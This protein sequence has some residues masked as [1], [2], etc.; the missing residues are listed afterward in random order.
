MAGDPDMM[1]IL[2]RCPEFAPLFWAMPADA[3]DSEYD[4]AVNAERAAAA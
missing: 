3:S 2:D 1:W 4:V